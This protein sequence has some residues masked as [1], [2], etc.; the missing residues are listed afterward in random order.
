M[1]SIASLP[2][3]SYIV[4][5]QLRTTVAEREAFLKDVGYNM[6]NFPARALLIDLLTDSGT[7][8]LPQSCLSALLSSD[9]AYSRHNWYYAFLDAFRD[10]CERGSK[11]LKNYLKLY[12]SN[13]SHEEY[14]K[15]FV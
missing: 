10:L 6:F 13:L 2:P 7:C 1:E 12:D 8:A 14:R 5:K 11:P 4:K 9:E 15:T 3:S